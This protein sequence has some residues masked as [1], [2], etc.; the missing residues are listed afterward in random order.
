MLSANADT[1]TLPV[2]NDIRSMVFNLFGVGYEIVGTGPY[3]NNADLTLL[4]LNPQEPGR[5]NVIRDFRMS[6]SPGWRNDYYKK[7]LIH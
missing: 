4:P 2:I 7:L 1:G 3:V 5:F 6:I